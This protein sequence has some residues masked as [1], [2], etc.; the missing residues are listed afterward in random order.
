MESQSKYKAEELYTMALEYYIGAGRDKSITQARSCLQES[1]DMGLAKAINLLADLYLKKVFPSNNY[2]EAIEL[3]KRGCELG[4][5]RSPYLLGRCYENGQGVDK[6]IPM[7]LECYEKSYNLGNI[8][9]CFPIARIYETGKE[10]ECNLLEAVSWYEKG[11]SKGDPECACNLGFCYYIGKG[12]EKD[13]DRAKDLFLAHSDY[14]SEIQKN[15]G[16]IYYKGTRTCKPNIE[17]AKKWFVKAS[18]NGNISSMINLGRIYKEEKNRTVAMEWYKKAAELDSKKGAYFYGFHLYKYEEDKWEEAY[19]WIKKS[20][21]NKHPSAEFLLGLFYKCG[22]GIPVDHTKALYWFNIAAE[23]NYEQ[24]YSHIGRYYRDGRFVSQNFEIASYWFEKAMFSE[25]KNVKGEALYDYGIMY[26]DGK[27]KKKNRRKG[28]EYLKK[29]KDLECL[30]AINK[31][32]EFSKREID[33]KHK[34]DTS[35]TDFGTIVDYVEMK[36]KEG[37]VGAKWVPNVLE[38]L[39]VYVDVAKK[40]DLVKLNDNGK[41]QWQLTNKDYAQWILYVS[42]DLQLYTITGKDKVSYYPTYFARLFLNKKSAGFDSKQ[43]SHFM[44]EINN[45]WDKE[46]KNCKKLNDFRNKVEDELTKKRL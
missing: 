23:D 46:V 16:V 9:A 15:L 20:A 38:K 42:E 26:L 33:A 2:K 12:V 5:S 30:N 21:E 43:I 29:S 7:A 40:C 27:G 4:D 44:Y 45:E 24:A 14:N 39:R 41:W 22:V 8:G 37:N 10:V 11:A 3:Y 13:F 6:N 1:A 35:V 32:K 31:L 19:K 28:L 18:E 36:I 17:M 25:D 34:E